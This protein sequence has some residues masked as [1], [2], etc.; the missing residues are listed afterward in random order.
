MKALAHLDV[1]EHLRVWRRHVLPLF[2]LVG[3][4]LLIAFV[5]VRA[6][7]QG[8]VIEDF[9]PARNGLLESVGDAPFDP[10]LAVLS[11][12][13]LTLAPEAAVF[14]DSPLSAPV[15]AEPDAIRAV[16]DGRV[17]FAGPEGKGFTV[18]LLHQRGG[19]HLETV[20]AGMASARVVVGALLRRGQ[21]LGPIDPA[22]PDAFR[23]VRRDSLSLTTAKVPSESS[24][25]PAEWKGRKEDLVYPPPVGAK[26]APSIQID[27]PVPGASPE[28]P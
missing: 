26:L 6:G 13:E 23:F 4:T 17:I 2:T 14:L 16:A 10:A 27:A 28:A 12:I 22:N 20:Y 9:V 15:E 24:G 21:A 7:Q 18:I 25:I 3:A 19:E 8:P 1:K 5:I 11:P